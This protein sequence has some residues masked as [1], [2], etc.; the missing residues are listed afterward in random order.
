MANSTGRKRSS[1][2]AKRLPRRHI[3]HYD[4]DANGDLTTPTAS[5]ENDTELRYRH[6]FWNMILGYLLWLTV[7]VLV[8]LLAYRALPMIFDNLTSLGVAGLLLA[9]A[10]RLSPE[11]LA[12]VAKD[13]LPIINQNRGL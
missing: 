6:R 9:I 2:R 4:P 11:H 8:F 5:M 1:R 12:N 3:P 10:C 7:V 13:L